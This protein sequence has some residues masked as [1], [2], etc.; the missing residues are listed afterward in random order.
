MDIHHA[1]QKLIEELKAPK[2]WRESLMMKMLKDAN[3]VSSLDPEQAKK[4]VK[5]LLRHVE[6]LKA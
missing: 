3:L 6:V 4:N 5:D 2:N 1:A